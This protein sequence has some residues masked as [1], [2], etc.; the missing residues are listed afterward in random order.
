MERWE[1]GVKRRGDRKVM[2]KD[3]VVGM[4]GKNEIEGQ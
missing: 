2:G 1:D 4:C 3:V